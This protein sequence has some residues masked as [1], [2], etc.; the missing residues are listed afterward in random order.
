VHATVEANH[1]PYGAVGCRTPGSEK[2]PGTATSDVSLG[3]GKDVSYAVVFNSAICDCE[4]YIDGAQSAECIKT[5]EPT[6]RTALEG[7]PCASQALN[8]ADRYL[9][10]SYS[11]NRIGDGGSPLWAAQRHW[12]QA[13]NRCVTSGNEDCVA[14][15]RARAAFFDLLAGT[16]SGAHRLGWI[17]AESGSVGNGGYET[18]RAFYRFVKP[19]TPGEDL[20]NKVI[21][22]VFMKTRDSVGAVQN[23]LGRST[24]RRC[25][26]WVIAGTAT[27]D[28]GVI[29][30]PIHSFFGCSD[31]Q[32]VETMSFITVDMNRAIVVQ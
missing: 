31:P 9:N 1:T 11:Q 28:S 10:S 7:E 15:T 3:G 14:K 25:F 17:G 27:L 20:F 19:A 26:S 2:W 8:D 32:A 12:V 18:S 5:F 29:R 24:D 4:H 6:K 23:D 21:W 13:R 30:V 16:E 22:Q